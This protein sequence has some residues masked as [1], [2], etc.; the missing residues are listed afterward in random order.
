[1]T[2]DIHWTVRKSGHWLGRGGPVNC[3]FEAKRFS[4]GWRLRVGSLPWAERVYKT[5]HE[6][7]DA[8]EHLIPRTT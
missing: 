7:A 4:A 3:S 1:M 5:F 8:A 2:R 6:L